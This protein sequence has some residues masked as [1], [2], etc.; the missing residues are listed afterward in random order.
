MRY[1]MA[2]DLKND[3][4]LIEEYKNHHQKVW[5]EILD[6]IR[7]V[8]ILDMQIF[9]IANRMFM[10]MDVVEGFDFDLQMQKLG[11]LPR[12]KEWEKFM[13]DFQQALPWANEGEKWL[14]MEKVFQL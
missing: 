3:P 11:N 1:C 5:K 12:Q 9:L 14:P 4:K 6:G 10:I 13:W 2:L 8:G 7:E